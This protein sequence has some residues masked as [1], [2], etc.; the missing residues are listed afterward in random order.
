[1]TTPLADKIK[2][3]IRA[4]GPISVTDYFALCLADPDHGYY[5]TRDPFG[6]N[7]DF[8][9]A[10]E[11][12]QLFGEMLG[13]FMVHAWQQHGSPTPANLVEVGPGRG[14]MMQDMLRVIRRLAPGLYENLDVHMVETSD[15]LRGVQRVTLEAY[16]SKIT[17]HAAFEDVPGGF[18]LIAAN[19]LFDAIPIRQFIK[20]PT[21]F[22]ERMV[23]LDANDR[24]TFG[25]GI[26]TIDPALLPSSHAKERDGTIFEIAPARQ[27]VMSAL[28]DRLKRHGGTALIID[29]GHMVTGFGDTLQAVLRHDYDP[30]LAHPGEA[31]LTSHVD[32]EDLARIARGSGIQINGCL[33]QGDFLYGLG[34]AERAAAL[35]SGKSEPE[36]RAIA[37]SA[38]R[39]AGAGEGKMGELFKVLS[40]SSPSV[41]LAPFRPARD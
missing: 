27:A 38:D 39:L 24:L 22:R 2:N 25:V 7:G 3:L 32:F 12:S 9:T 8:V 41:T 26:A 17:W 33:H 14:T 21:G 5:R 29:Y 20:T 1:M 23:G 31:D 19:E 11:I 40:V 18:T 10:P 13:I 37:V 30:P 16:S 28:C 6:R 35:A 15:R 36:Q 4:N 34:L